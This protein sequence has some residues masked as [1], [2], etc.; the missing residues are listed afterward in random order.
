MQLDGQLVCLGSSAFDILAVIV[1]AGGRPVTRDELMNAVW[2]G[3]IVEEGNIDVHMSALR[4]V[5]GANR[6]L[7]VTVPGR[8]YQLARPHI[9]RRRS[10]PGR[11]QR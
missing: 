10:N 11:R 2:P 5:L 6:D 3:V 4:K 7:I 1:C 8:G 9:S